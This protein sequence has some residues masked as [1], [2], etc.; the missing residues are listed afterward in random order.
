M[1]L[2]G[3]F[4]CFRIAVDKSSFFDL[5]KENCHDINIWLKKHEFINPIYY[6]TGKAQTEMITLEN[7][8]V[9]KRKWLSVSL[10]VKYNYYV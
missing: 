7:I 4:F 6:I 1:S 8:K 5:W 9:R 3:L 2:L 10:F